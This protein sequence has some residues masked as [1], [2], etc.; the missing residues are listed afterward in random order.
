MLLEVGCTI[1]LGTIP[2]IIKLSSIIVGDIVRSI[3]LRPHFRRSDLVESLIHLLITKYFLITVLEWTICTLGWIT[4]LF[5]LSRYYGYI[6]HEVFYIF[7]LRILFHVMII[8]LDLFIHAMSFSMLWLLLLLLLL[9]LCTIWI[10]LMMVRRMRL[11]RWGFDLGHINRC[12]TILWL[13]LLS[14]HLCTVKKL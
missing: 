11:R 10:W 7:L 3:K 9:L 4:P 2:R 12:R 13:L 6:I 14:S 8:C 1:L 5:N